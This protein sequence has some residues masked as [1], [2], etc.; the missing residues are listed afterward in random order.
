MKW[1]ISKKGNKYN[2]KRIEIDG[3]IPG[4]PPPSNLLGNILIRLIER[5]EINLPERSMCASCPL[6]T[7][8]GFDLNTEI[9]KLF[10][11]SEQIFAPEENLECFLKRGIL[12]LGPIVRDGCEH[13]CIKE[14]N[15]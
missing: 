4:C 6:R 12:C 3:I 15:V 2:A 13:I 10:P 14:G 9:I 1:Q 7:E 11:E 5:K 8:T